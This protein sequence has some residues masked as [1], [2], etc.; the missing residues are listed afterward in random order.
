M[1]VVSQRIARAGKHAA[2]SHT[3]LWSVVLVVVLLASMTVAITIGPAQLST[4]DVWPAW[5]TTLAWGTPD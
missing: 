3:V 5:P 4:A 2:W 1:T